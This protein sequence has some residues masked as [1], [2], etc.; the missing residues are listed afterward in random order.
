[1]SHS[2]RIDYEGISIACRGIC[3]LAASQL[4]K[5]DTMLNKIEETS[6]LL[7]NEETQGL[8][9]ELKAIKDSLRSKINNLI[10]NSKFVG[11]I[12]AANE[13]K[14]EVN[15]LTGKQIF[16]YES[17]LNGLL[18]NEVRKT[19]GEMQERARGIVR[20]N[21]DFSQNLSNI[22]DEVLKSY[23]YLA[24]IDKKNTGKKFSE[25]KNIAE[26]KMKESIVSHIKNKKT[27]ILQAIENDMKEAKVD[28]EKIKK[29]MHLGGDG[30]DNEQIQKIREKAN[31]E[32][33]TESIR[34]ETLKVIRS[35]I[36]NRGFKIVATKLQKDVNEVVMIAQK[37][38]GEIAKF[39]VMLDGKFIYEFKDGY[40]GQACRK[41][42]EPF[43]KDLQ[44][45]Y[46]IKIKK[47]EEIWSNPDKENWT[48]TND[49][50][51]N[52]ILNRS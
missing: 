26:S 39:R 15:R 36:E 7:L 23:I 8:R 11:A 38:S 43:M 12:E 13:L 32:I 31:E 9:Q 50:N 19:A 41:D 37:V 25:L 47:Q 44:D 5:I 28:D 48:Y 34:K 42:T 21:E 22:K 2:V 6:S 3:E 52:V 29:V 46:G 27:A 45:I 33:I 40:K 4:C 1:M 10:Q 49:T 24:W 51:G 18:A 30:N 16:A 35:A 20:Y 14:S 17:L